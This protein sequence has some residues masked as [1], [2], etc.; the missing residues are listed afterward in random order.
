M[1][2]ICKKIKGAVIVISE[3]TSIDMFNK[4]ACGKALIDADKSLILDCNNEEVETFNT[5]VNAVFN[6]AKNIYENTCKNCIKTLSLIDSAICGYHPKSNR[7][8]SSY[9]LIG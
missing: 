8:C 7:L 2:R 9:E 5:P 3:F 6:A 4:S 1:I